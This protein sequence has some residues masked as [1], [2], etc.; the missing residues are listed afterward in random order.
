MTCQFA[1]TCGATV[2]SALA[3][4]GKD[5]RCPHGRGVSQVHGRHRRCH[6]VRSPCVKKLVKKMLQNS[7]G[8][9]LRRT[10]QAVKVLV[11]GNGLKIEAE[12]LMTGSALRAARRLRQQ[13]LDGGD[14]IG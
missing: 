3:G 1:G 7:G 12:E 2:A 13:G 10:F 5:L 14:E 9:P 4:Y 6:L 8:G 11:V